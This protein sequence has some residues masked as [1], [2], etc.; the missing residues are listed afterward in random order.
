MG[1]I[2]NGTGSDEIGRDP[3]GFQREGEAE[4]EAEEE[5]EE[6]GEEEGWR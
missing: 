6:K 5:A 2:S 3:R 4:A 1:N